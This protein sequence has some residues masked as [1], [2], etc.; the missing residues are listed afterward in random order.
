MPTPRR[1]SPPVSTIRST[2]PVLRP[3]SRDSVQDRIYAEL[4]DALICGRL[5]GGQTL[6]IRALAAT[7]HTSVMPVREALRRLVAEGALES[8]TQR[9]VRVPSM[10]PQ[11]LDDIFQARLLVE[12]RAAEMA[13]ANVDDDLLARLEKADAAFCEALANPDPDAELTAN[14]EFHFTLYAASGSPALL[15]IIRSLWLQTGP[16]LRLAVERHRP[17]EVGPR[18]LYHHDVMQALRAKDAA[19]TRRALEADLSWSLNLLKQGA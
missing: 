19:A 7:F 18:T 16:F 8:S 12:G 13:A 6:Q 3:V 2:R 1:D 17:E 5:Q 10:T 9:P 4:C 11:R 14:R 15:A